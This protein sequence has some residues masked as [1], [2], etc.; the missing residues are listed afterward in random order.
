MRLDKELD[1]ITQ[2]LQGLYHAENQLVL[3]LPRVAA[4]VSNERLHAALQ[5]HLEQTRNHALRVEL[6]AQELGVPCSGKKCLAMEGLLKEGEES[7]G[8][9]G[10]DVLVDAAIIA[11]CQAVEHF[12][13]SQYKALCDLCEQAGLGKAAHHLTLTLDEEQ[14]ASKE[15][16]TIAQSM[17]S[18]Q[19]QAAI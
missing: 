10:S 1:L 17:R 12:E 9:G 7:M 11:S 16:A 6:V 18:E 8:Y 15:L 19:S 3:A 2:M 4:R 14:Q 13:I 5:D